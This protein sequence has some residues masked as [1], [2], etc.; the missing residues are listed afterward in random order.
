MAL[1]L[2]RR[3]SP[4]HTRG[5]RRPPQSGVLVPATSAH[6]PQNIGRR[7]AY[8]RVLRPVRSRNGGHDASGPS[9]H[10]TITLREGTYAGARDRLSDRD[11]TIGNRL[12]RPLSRNETI[13]P[14]PR[15]WRRT[16]QKV[17]LNRDTLGDWPAPPPVPQQAADHPEQTVERGERDSEAHP[18]DGDTRID[19]EPFH[20]ES[21]RAVAA[22]TTT[23]KPA[24]RP[25]AT[26]VVERARERD[27]IAETHFRF[28]LSCWVGMLLLALSCHLTQRQ[29]HAP[30]ACSQSPQYSPDPHH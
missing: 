16:L 12:N 6:H 24:P 10:W 14:H 1:T 25:H 21:N 17:P 18:E 4:V 15:V 29:Y 2:G 22:A 19:D 5:V 13:R 7:A 11:E 9:G 8:G 26:R 30:P 3:C 23:R 28:D 20:R 27:A